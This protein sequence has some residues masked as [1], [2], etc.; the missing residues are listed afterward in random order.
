[1]TTGFFVEL[2]D[3]VLYD[4][5]GNPATTDDQIKVDGSIGLQPSID[6]D[7]DIDSSRITRLAFT[8]Q[9]SETTEITLHSEVELF[10]LQKKFEV[11]RYRLSPFTVWVGYVPVVI[12]PVVTINVGLDG[13]VSV[14]LEAGA[15]QTA[16]LTA[17]LAYSN[18]TWTHKFIVP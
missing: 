11:A 15:T 8:T 1:M 17:G 4:D 2:N 14:G 16:T 3:V 5:D 18:G 12:L 13:K 6:F 7:L 9:A 10:S